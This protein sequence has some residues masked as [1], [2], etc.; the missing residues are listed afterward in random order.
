MLSEEFSKT[1]LMV[2][3]LLKD[4]PGKIRQSLARRAPAFGD[5]R[6]IWRWNRMVPRPH[7]EKSD[8]R[9]GIGLK[10]H[11]AASASTLTRASRSHSRAVRGGASPK[12]P[13]EALASDVRG[14]GVESGSLCL[15]F[16]SSCAVFMA[17]AHFC[18]P[19]MWPASSCRLLPSS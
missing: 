9:W 6:K 5:P 19:V 1:V 16:A 3:G 4:A 10:D 13:V 18:M 17:K 12:R 7:V 2:L 15:H 14:P 8:V 11:V